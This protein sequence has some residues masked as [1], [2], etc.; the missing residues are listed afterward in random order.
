VKGGYQMD[1]RYYLVD[2]NALIDDIDVIESHKVVITSHVLR[3]LEKHKSQK[4]DPALA[5]GARHAVR[6]V[7]EKRRNGSAILVD[8]KDYNWDLNDTYDKDYVDNMLLK[9]CVENDYGIITNDGLLI[10]KAE[11]YN[12][13]IIE[14]EANNFDDSYTGVHDF[15][16]DYNN[17]EHARVLMDIM[18]SDLDKK[19]INHFN[20]VLN[21]Y[22][23]I[24]NANEPEY[25][26]NNELIGH[27]LVDG[28]NG[29]YRWDGEKHVRVKFDYSLGD[30]KPVNA[31]QRLMFHMLQNDK[32]K[33]KSA[34]GTF[35]VGKDFVMISHALQMLF[36]PNCEIDRIVWVR[37][38]VELKDS[39]PIGFL[40]GDKIEKL[41]E[42]AMPLADHVGGVETLRGMIEDGRIEIQHLG[43]LRGRDIK[44]SIIYVTEVQNNTRDHIKLLLG[45]V[46]EGSQLW[47]NGDL[48][49]S[50]KD[51]FRRNSGLL[52]LKSLAGNPLYAQVTL[53]KIERSDTAK[54]A[55]LLED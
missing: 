10:L 38:N 15:F 5:Y 26:D 28:F 21:Q 48:K 47:L 37:N 50:D 45:R 55:E 8:L 20:L 7:L 51:A 54:L 31:K 35:G 34:F 3:E 41:L 53:D 25:N 14:L 18:S 27:K 39:E 42:F 22:L 43:T 13:P 11:M 2:T 12:I 49:Q 4:K 30:I 52:A 17:A 6:K 29:L 36:D 16:Y 44:N 46:G 33:V 24:W 40:P 23:V 9:A 19:K 32:I 1:E